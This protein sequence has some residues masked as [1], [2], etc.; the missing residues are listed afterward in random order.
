MKK[1]PLYCCFA[2]LLVSCITPN[3]VLYLQDMNDESQIELEHKYEARIAVQDQLSI[4]VTCSDESLAEPFNLFG[5]NLSNT[6]ILNNSLSGYLVDINGEIDFPI[7]GKVK[8]KG[9]TR[10]EL[11]KK[12]TDILVEGKY[13]ENPL[14]TIRYTN[15]KIFY[16]GSNGG[17]VLN[18]S[19]ERCTL[20]EALAMMG[21]LDNYTRR[22]KISII[23]EVDGKM[24]MRYLDP[25]SSE[26]F[27]DPYFLLQQNDFVI[28]ES[29]K[30]QY[31]KQEVSYWL[32]WVSVF[33]SISSIITMLLLL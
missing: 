1:T 16:L 29:I 9:L 21:G 30:G 8:V 10:L 15:F 23:R 20:L 17:G 14:V 27:N 12:L 28:T 5:Q 7:L 18:I 25:R 33:T 22:D 26:V 13:L 19:N 2:L 32:S 24:T 3:R 4:V 6:N 31:Y 11:Q